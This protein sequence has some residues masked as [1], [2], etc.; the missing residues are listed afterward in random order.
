MKEEFAFSHAH[1]SYLEGRERK[2]KGEYGRTRRKFDRSLRKPT[3]SLAR[4]TDIIGLGS[5]QSIAHPSFR[6]EQYR[7]GLLVYQRVSS[8]SAA[9]R[10]GRL[11]K[12]LI[13]EHHSWLLNEKSNRSNNFDLCI[14]ANT[15]YIRQ[16]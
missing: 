4:V 1:V 3:F 6:R 8:Y 10:M 16:I 5:D 9:S 2:I 15:F 14:L 11:S 7:V 13:P 12:S